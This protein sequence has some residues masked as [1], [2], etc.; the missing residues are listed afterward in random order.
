MS[1]QSWNDDKP[2]RCPACHAIAID[3][4]RP[5]P[6]KIYTCCQCDVRFARWPK[7]RWVLR[8]VGIV[9]TVHRSAEL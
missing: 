9:Y 8:D 3:K 4:E 5:S 2:H 6:L 1:M 7:L